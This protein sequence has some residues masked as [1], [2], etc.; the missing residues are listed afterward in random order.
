VEGCLYLRNLNGGVSKPPQKEQP[1]RSFQVAGSVSLSFSF[2]LDTAVNRWAA[3]PV[4]DFALKS[5]KNVSAQPSFFI[6]VGKIAE[7]IPLAG[8]KCMEK[9]L[10]RAPD[11]LA[12]EQTIMGQ[13]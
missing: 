8:N 11:N 10:E 3:F 9:K 12:T 6:Y 4:F 13:P 2:P 7:Q 1:Q 5:T